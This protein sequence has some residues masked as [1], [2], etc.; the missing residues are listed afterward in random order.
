MLNSSFP[1]K[2]RQLSGC[3]VTMIGNQ[4]SEVTI[5]MTYDDTGYV[6]SIVLIGNCPGMTPTDGAS[7]LYQNTIHTLH[8]KQTLQREESDKSVRIVPIT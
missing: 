7:I 5:H 4:L 6:P 1:F 8:A 3:E 2:P